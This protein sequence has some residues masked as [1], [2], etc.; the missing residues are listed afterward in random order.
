MFRILRENLVFYQQKLGAKASQ[1][2]TGIIYEK[3]L[4]ISSA[5]NKL[6]SKGDIITF[7][8]VDSQKLLFLFET[9]P[10]VSKLPFQIVFCIVY[11]YLFVGWTF[12]IALGI[13][14]VFVVGNYFLAIAISKY[15]KVRMKAVG[16]RTNAV[17][18]VIDNIK[19]IKFYS[20]IDNFMEKANKTRNEELWILFKRLLLWI[21]NISFFVVGYPILACSIFISATLWFDQTISVPYAIAILQVLSSLQSSTRR[22]PFFI[23]QV[24]EFLISM[25]R[26]QTFLLT[27]EIEKDQLIYQSKEAETDHSV[28][29]SESNFY[30]GF[31]KPAEPKKGRKAKKAIKDVERADS[32]RGSMISQRTV[33]LDE[34]VN[35][36]FQKSVLGKSTD[37][38]S[39]M[40]MS[41]DLEGSKMTQLSQ[42][43]GLQDIDLEVK[44]G[45]FIAIIGEV[46][47]GKSS[48]ISSIIGDMLFVDQDTMNTFAS[49][50]VHEVTKKSN[51]DKI[52][53]MN[54][55]IFDNFEKTRKENT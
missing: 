29:I 38:Y 46:G 55:D 21:C 44:H 37:T 48:I 8:Q 7:I 27:D 34:N 12:L 30:W 52:L 13:I 25:N 45:E 43:V 3:I 18:E 33:T 28:I 11:L 2:V 10:T 16:K 51:K 31:E 5:T 19:L 4:K 35:M 22:L 32:M 39:E 6:H 15:Q 49:E 50:E 53:K 47:S 1:S 36:S 9:L 41:Q 40:S 23:G 14:S 54:Q 26:I 42:K 20:W 24:V 17:S